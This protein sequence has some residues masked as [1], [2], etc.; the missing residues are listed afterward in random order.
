[1][2]SLERSSI[3]PGASGESRKKRR[4]CSELIII[5][6]SQ[7]SAV[8]FHSMSKQTPEI[9]SEFSDRSP[10]LLPA[11]IFMFRFPVLRQGRMKEGRVDTVFVTGSDF[12]FVFYE[13][14][15]LPSGDETNTESKTKK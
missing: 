1:M 10:T 6:R 2:R 8:F 15:K 13:T 9:L 11:S 4:I 7:K 14:T 12:S 3:T 5:T